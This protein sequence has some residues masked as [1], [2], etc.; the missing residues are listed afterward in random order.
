MLI[1]KIVVAIYLMSLASV[2]LYILYLDV[3]STATITEP[4]EPTQA[5]WSSN[6]TNFSFGSFDK[7]TYSNFI[8]VNIHNN[9]NV[10]SYELHVAPKEDISSDLILKSYTMD[11]LEYGIEMPFPIVAPDNSI[12]L[13]I[14][15]YATPE[16][17]AHLVNFHTR[18]SGI[19]S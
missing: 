11:D 2:G 5:L 14:R 3:N 7:G 19:E 18:F 17:T 4:P 9:D 8:T 13:K 15:L 16:A 10:N 6:V 12:T 1:P